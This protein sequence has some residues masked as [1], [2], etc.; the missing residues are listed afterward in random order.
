MK[1]TPASYNCPQ[2]FLGI[3]SSLDKSQGRSAIWLLLLP[4]WSMGKND[5]VY[6]KKEKEQISSFLLRELAWSHDFNVIPR[7]QLQFKEF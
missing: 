4:I 7:N 6:M 1:I 3:K 5:P 2:K